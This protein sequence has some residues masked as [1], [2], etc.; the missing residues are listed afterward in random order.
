MRPTIEN[1]H[2]VTQ[3]QLDEVQRRLGIVLPPRLRAVICEVK[4]MVRPLD[5]IIKTGHT[6]IRDK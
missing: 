3:S 2:P 6:S 1:L 4:K 5:K